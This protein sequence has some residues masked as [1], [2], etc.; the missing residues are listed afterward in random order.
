LSPARGRSAA[1][2][3]PGVSIAAKRVHAWVHPSRVSGHRSIGSDSGAPVTQI[4]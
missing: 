1:V 3:V 2:I 4:P